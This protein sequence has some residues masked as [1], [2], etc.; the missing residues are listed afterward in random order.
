MNQIRHNRLLRL[1]IIPLFLLSVI[2]TIFYLVPNQIV[3]NDFLDHFKLTFPTTLILFL[4][5]AL[6][7][8]VFTVAINK[9]LKLIRKRISKLGKYEIFII[10]FFL[11][12]FLG[13]FSH[14]AM[15]R[16][17]NLGSGMYDFG[18][19]HQVVWNTSEGRLFETSVEVSNYLGDHFSLLVLIP[20]AI[21]KL[22]PG[23]ATILILQVLAVTLS[24]AGIYMLAKK[25]LH[26]RALGFVFMT[27]FCFYFGVSGLMLFEFHP[28]TFG[29]P[30][31]AWGLYFYE[32]TSWKKLASALFIL[33]AFAKEEIGMFVGMYGF[34]RVFLK[35]D[36][37]LTSVFLMIFGVAFSLAALFI[38]IPYF[39][40]GVPADTLVRYKAWGD[41]GLSILIN[42]ITHPIDVLIHIL[43]EPRLSYIVRLLLSVGFLP[44]FA[45]RVLIV[46]LPNLFINILTSYPPGQTSGFDHYDSITSLVMIWAAI[47]GFKNLSKKAGTYKYVLSILVFINMAAFLFHPMWRYVFMSDDT[48]INHYPFVSFINKSLPQDAIIAASNTVGAHLGAHR[49]LQSIDYDFD[50][51]D[52][53]PEYMVVDTRRDPKIWNSDKY[54]QLL[55]SKNYELI[56]DHNEF[57][58]YK[59][60]TLVSN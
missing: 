39:R 57:E 4:L 55:N 21:Y 20:A 43:G 13:L 35:K 10:I 11:A 53:D 46:L 29:L 12:I 6:A 40:G 49:N 38:F 2:F 50:I 25:T 42:V 9:H 19:E 52:Q 32:I 16:H 54:K 58:V 15:K 1:Y 60:K 7:W 45:P 17:Y 47:V 22:F 44:L 56:W 36:R 3:R 33:G 26:S 14:F 48:W 27:V 18:L 59:L 37:S 34:Y 24:A 41:S 28:V 23:D 30:F 8:T 51:Y 5:A 31:L